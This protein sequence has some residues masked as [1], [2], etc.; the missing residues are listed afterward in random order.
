MLLNLLI[1]AMHAMPAGGAI[2]ITARRP[3]APAAILEVADTGGGIPEAI[4]GRIFDSFL[5]SRPDGT[6]LGLSIARRI[7]E[8]HNG[9]IAL[10][11]TGPQGTTFRITLPL[12]K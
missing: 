11:D 8:G 10:V 7:L 12:A 1:N 2:A 9:N 5:S 3:R 4:R 6:G